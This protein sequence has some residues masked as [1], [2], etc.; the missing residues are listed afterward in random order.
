MTAITVRLSDEDHKLLQ[1]YCVVSGKSQNAV[2]TELLHA[3]LD[4]ALPGKRDALRSAN[5]DALWDA[6]GMAR[7]EPGPAA[8]KWS[9]GVINSL[10][11]E[12]STSRPAA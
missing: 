2:M 12:S 6:L 4:R 8:Q 11:D 10:R 7:P 9:A 5:P 3:E 1:L